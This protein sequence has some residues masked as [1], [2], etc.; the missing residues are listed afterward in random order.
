MRLG[1]EDGHL[2]CQKAGIHPHPIHPGFIPPSH[3]GVANGWM[4]GSRMER[5]SDR[6]P[7]GRVGNPCHARLSRTGLG[8]VSFR[9][10]DLT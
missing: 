8:L 1:R 4:D 9:L 6:E 7:Q 10:G 3:P 5:H 2:Q